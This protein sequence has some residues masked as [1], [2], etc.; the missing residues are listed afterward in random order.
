MEYMLCHDVADVW[1]VDNTLQFNSVFSLETRHSV[2]WQLL[3]RVVSANASAPRRSDW[4]S[5]GASDSRPI[6]IGRL[7]LQ[8]KGFARGLISQDLRT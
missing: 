3:L 7:S 2:V 8:I 5:G 1:P 6:Y 4:G